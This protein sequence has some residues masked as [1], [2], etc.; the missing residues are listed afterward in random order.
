MPPRGTFA[1]VENHHAKITLLSGGMDE[2]RFL[3][4]I[5]VVLVIFSPASAS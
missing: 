1:P 3:A 2:S 5:G 4:L